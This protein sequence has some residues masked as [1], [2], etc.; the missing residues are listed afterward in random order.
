MSI[1]EIMLRIKDKVLGFW[2]KM[3]IGGKLTGR[4]IRNMV[5]AKW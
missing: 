1:R 3:A 2:H 5:R 4:T